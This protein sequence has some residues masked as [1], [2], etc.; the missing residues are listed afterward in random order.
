MNLLIIALDRFTP[1]QAA[2][3]D[4]LVV[5]PPLNSRL[6]RWLSDEDGV[7]VKAAARVSAWVDRL[8]KTGARVEGRVGVLAPS[9]RPAPS[10]R[11]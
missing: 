1:V 6:H 3:A 4:V 5:A 9:T 2:T 7:R 11:E 8:Q 10:A